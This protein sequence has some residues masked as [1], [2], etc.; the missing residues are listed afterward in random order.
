MSRQYKVSACVDRISIPCIKRPVSAGAFVGVAIAALTT[1]TALADPSYNLDGMAGMIHM[2][3]GEAMED[4]ELAVTASYFAGI[5]RFNQTFQLHDRVSATLRYSRYNHWLDGTDYF[6]RSFDLRFNVLKE[7]QFVPAVTIGLTDI[8]GT[9]YYSSEFIAATKNF[10]PEFRATAGIGWGRLG[11]YNSFSDGFD[12]RSSNG[13]DERDLFRGSMAGFAGIEWRPIDKLTLKA[14]YSSDAHILETE[15]LDAFEHKSPFNFGAEYAFNEYVTLGA[16]SL[17]GSELAA[18]LTFRFN[19][20][21]PIIS[22]GLGSAPRAVKPRPP[23]AA[24]PEQYSTVWLEQA[25]VKELLVENTAKFMEADRIVLEGLDID[26][27]VVEARIRNRSFMSSAQAVGRSARA[28]SQTMPPSVKTF[29]IIPVANGLAPT[30]VVIDRSDLENFV[31]RPPG[32][33]QMLQSVAFE[34]AGPPSDDIIYFEGTYPKFTWGLAPYVRFDIF[35]PNEPVEWGIGG[36]LTS[37]YEIS[38]GWEVSGGI[39]AQVVGSIGDGDPQPVATD[40]PPVRSNAKLYDAFSPVSLTNLT[41]D[42]YFEPQN[43][44]YG[45]I[46]VGYLEPMFGGI[47][48]EL[49]W[50]P[51]DTPYAFGAE[52]NYV[53]QRDYDSY[54]GFQDYETFTGHVSAYYQASN[55]FDFRVDA[56]RYLAGDYGATFA[57]NREF[58]SGWRIGAFISRT[59]ESENDPTGDGTYNKGIVLEVPYHWITGKPT[60][61]TQ[62]VAL[63]STSRNSAARL[64]VDQR[65]YDK[66][67]DNHA[68]NLEE[69]WGRFWR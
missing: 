66:V 2:P 61:S 42:Y 39:N 36:R 41:M 31:S 3:S 9:G 68:E 25:G 53:K 7:S 52:L 65:L 24:D 62:T 14:E 43:D 19:P 58:A 15:S 23:Y 51:V 32:Q 47:A 50:K 4:A 63:Q 49:L 6:D 26:G 5:S 33:D 48:S 16:Y 54:L 46:S 28:L 57:I 13:V 27:T 37:K 20:K 45:R 17:Y 35:Q 44:V 38:R 21:K 55:G 11:S 18:Q 69:T 10:T 59:N 1:T 22:T 8:S 67:R 30:A 29:R 60:R 12:S 56:G 34:E 40:L 64:R